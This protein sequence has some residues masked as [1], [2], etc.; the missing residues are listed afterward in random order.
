[1]ETLIVYLLGAFSVLTIEFTVF[2]Y[3]I[4]QPIRDLIEP[5]ARLF[6]QV[7]YAA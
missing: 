5:F 2:D 3:V 6:E 1:M 7:I 4:L